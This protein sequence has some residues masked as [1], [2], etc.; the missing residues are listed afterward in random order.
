MAANEI[1]MFESLSPL[2]QA[3]LVGK[4]EHRTV[5]AGTVLFR[6]HEPGDSLYILQKG[7]VRVYHEENGNRQPIG[8]IFEGETFG[9]M[10]LLIDEPRFGRRPKRSPNVKFTSCRSQCFRN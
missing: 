3:R 4:L 6:Q 10:A 5:S 9:E 8:E 2:E 1:R 7:R